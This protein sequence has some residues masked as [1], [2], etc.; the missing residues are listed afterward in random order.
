LIQNK[1]LPHLFNQ[2]FSVIFALLILVVAVLTAVFVNYINDPFV[3]VL[4][5]LGMLLGLLFFIK[6]Y[7]GSLLLILSFP[8]I[9]TLSRGTFLPVLRPDEAL[10][11]F[12][13]IVSMFSPVVENRLYLTKVDILFLIIIVIVFINTLLGSIFRAEE[14]YWIQIFSIGKAYII[15][16]LLLVTIDTREKLSKAVYFLIIPS[17]VVC[18]I[19]FMQ[20]L[21]FGGMLNLLAKIYPDTSAAY[22][23]TH[24]ATSVLGNWNALGAYSVFGFLLC[25]SLLTYEQDN[26]RT[27]ILYIVMAAN[28]GCLAITGSSNSLIGLFIGTLVWII[29]KPK[30]YSFFKLILRREILLLIL[31]FSII[32]VIEG[33]A[34]LNFQFE[35]QFGSDTA[36]DLVT[37]KRIETHGLPNSV[38]I[39]WYLAVYMYQK[40]VEDTAALWVG[41]GRSP[42]AIAL[43]PWSTPESGYAGMV[44]FFGI[45]FLIAYVILYLTVYKT[46]SSAR[47]FFH[48]QYKFGQAISLSIMISTS[49]ILVMNVIHSYYLSGGIVHY[50]WIEVGLLVGLIKGISTHRKNF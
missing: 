32:F 39:R 46:A 10:I 26:K 30:S 2:Y 6:P 12:V 40:I 22:L 44:F 37:G 42:D 47:R 14:V 31:I 4:L 41:F 45:F 13:F 7:W 27:W 24:R 20:L 36:F 48:N 50:Y 49:A 9:S 35:R 1:F 25:L 11:I 23:Y 3:I 5:V 34:V 43:L 29:I 21:N 17:I 18:L 38:M 8:F 28:L 19:A 16:R 15:Y 33:S